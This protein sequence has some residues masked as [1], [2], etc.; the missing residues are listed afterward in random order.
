[1]TELETIKAY[2][3]LLERRLG[4]DLIIY[5][6]CGK[7]CETALASL[8]QLGKWHTNPYCLKIKS[9]KRLR[10]KCIRLKQNFVDKVLGGKGV[11][12]STC[13]C[14]VSEFVMPIRYGEHLVCMVAATG[15]LGDLP[16]R[17]YKNMSS[18][19]GMDAEQFAELRTESLKRL[20][21][22]AHV[23]AAIEILGQLISRYIT[24][25]TDIP[26][27]LDDAN[28]ED[29]EHVLMARKYIERHFAEPLC[30]DSVARHCH[31][32]KSHLE[33]LFCQSL[34]HGIAEEIRLC[35]L[36]LAKELLCTTDDSVKYISYL[37]GF[38]STDY[39]ATVFKRYFHLSPLQYRKQKRIDR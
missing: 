38:S 20:E 33:H 32:S 8:S 39:F 26:A 6:E 3:D 2:M 15:F 29:N 27:M 18:R 21:D 16:E 25:H 24:E 12:R 36:N 31:L 9:S 10:T 14:G 34:G 5:D 11:V 13:F 35:R 4:W 37:C 28:R 19:V 22:E 17:I 1:M 23:I 30:T 7:L